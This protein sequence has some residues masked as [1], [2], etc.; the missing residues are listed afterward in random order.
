MSLAENQYLSFDP[1]PRTPAVPPPPN[2]CDCPFHIS[3][4]SR[5][6]TWEGAAYECEGA[7][8]QWTKMFP[9]PEHCPTRIVLPQVGEGDAL[10]LCDITATA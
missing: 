5:H 9:A 2:R 6:K 10:I 3:G 4:D 8:S 7:T 1:N